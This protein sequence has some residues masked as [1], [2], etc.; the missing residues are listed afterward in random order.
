M[1]SVLLRL[2][3][4]VRFVL[5]APPFRLSASKNGVRA[6]NGRGREFESDCRRMFLFELLLK[7]CEN[8]DGYKI[9]R[10]ISAVKSRV[11]VFFFI[12]ATT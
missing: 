3:A 1:F 9:A 4:C 7:R 8:C 5:L 10:K 12:F 2:R 6:L 11:T